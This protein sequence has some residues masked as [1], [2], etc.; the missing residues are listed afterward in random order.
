MPADFECVS[1]AATVVDGVDRSDAAAGSVINEKT[2]KNVEIS[3]KVTF[4]VPIFV[5][6][7]FPESAGGCDVAM[8]IGELM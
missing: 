1:R 6:I 7:P 3:L 2:A 5:F 4:V 8:R